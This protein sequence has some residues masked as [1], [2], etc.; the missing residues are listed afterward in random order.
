MSRGSHYRWTIKKLLKNFAI[1]TRIYLCWSLFSI[2]PKIFRTD[3]YLEEHLRTAASECRISR[4]SHRKCNVR[5]GLLRNIVKFIGKH[6]CQSL[7]FNKVVGLRPATLLKKRL[8][9]IRSFFPFHYIQR[10]SKALFKSCQQ[11]SQKTSSSSE[12]VCLLICKNL[13]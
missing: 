5:N 2:K 9:H 6:L 12:Q 3:T 4:S 8:W 11:F 13:L 10:L 1:L 7:I